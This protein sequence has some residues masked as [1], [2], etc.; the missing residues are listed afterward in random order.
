MSPRPLLLAAVATALACTSPQS[1]VPDP[2]PEAKRFLDLYGSLYVGAYTVAA[3]AQ[4]KAV[5]D[6]TPEHDGARVAAG[7]A[8]AAVQGDRAAIERAQELLKSRTV[9]EPLQ[10]QG[11]QVKIPR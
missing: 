7:K 11:Q 10:G 3:E 8:L 1:A 5:T 2:K 6:V 9:L 4:W